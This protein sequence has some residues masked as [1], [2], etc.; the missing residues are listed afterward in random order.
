MSS[1]PKNVTSTTSSEPPKFAVPFLEQAFKASGN[2]YGGGGGPGS[3]LLPSAQGLVQ[4]TLGGKFL[5][6]DSNPYLEAT[7]NRGADL[8]QNRLNTSFGSQ[9]RDLAAARPAAADELGSFASQLFGNAYNFERQ[10]QIGAADQAQSFDPLNQFINRLA[11]LIP[12]AGGSTQSTQPVFRTG[13][14]SDRRLK[15]NITPKG[16]RYGC[17]WYEFEYLWGEKSEGVMSDEIPQK[18]VRKGV[19]DTVDYVALMGGK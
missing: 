4:D 6:P 5:S 15:R 18:Y 19:Y 13:L 2:A 7:F 12:G 17:K 1:G 8:I 3:N 16:E 11:G 14:F 9:G 10:N